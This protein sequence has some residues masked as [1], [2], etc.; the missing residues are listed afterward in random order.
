MKGNNNKELKT[1]LSP[2]E[3]VEIIGQCVEEL[4]H[5]Q[6][7]QCLDNSKNISGKND[8]VSEMIKLVQLIEKYVALREKIV[9]EKAEQE[10]TID[11]ALLH[12][13]LERKTDA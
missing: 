8:G 10:I 1:G 3:L 12:D 2:Q 5:R 6:T 11:Y 4:C 7:E 9:P 13:Y